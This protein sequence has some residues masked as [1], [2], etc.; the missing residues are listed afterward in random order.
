MLSRI[1]LTLLPTLPLRG[2]PHGSEV[3]PRHTKVARWIRATC[4]SVT[5]IGP[6]SHETPTFRDV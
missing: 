5:F 4:A 1:S 3:G 2:A 6:Q